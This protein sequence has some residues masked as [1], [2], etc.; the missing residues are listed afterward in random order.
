LDANREIEA[1]LTLRSPWLQPG[2]YALD[3]FLC[4]A[5]VIDAWEGAC[6]FQVLPDLP[7]P[8]TTSTDGVER[9]A[10]LGDFE[11]REW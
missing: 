1:T 5:G 10:V 7:Y 11:Y 3:L 9:G 4:R 2:R 6:S 8:N